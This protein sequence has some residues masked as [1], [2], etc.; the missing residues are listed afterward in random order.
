M[1]YLQAT[2]VA[3]AAV[4]AAAAGL[5]AYPLLRRERPGAA[6]GGGNKENYGEP[7]G[8]LRAVHRDELGYRGWADAPGDFEGST[9]SALSAYVMRSA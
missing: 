1:T 3:L 7:P 6:A 5:W 4:V 9:A 8:T 2:L